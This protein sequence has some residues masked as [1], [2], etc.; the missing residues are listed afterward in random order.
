LSFGDMAMAGVK[1]HGNFCAEV[2]TQFKKHLQ[3]AEEMFK[4]FVCHK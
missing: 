4:F 2:A 3:L 1:V